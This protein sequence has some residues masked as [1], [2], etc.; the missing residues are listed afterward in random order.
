MST[1]GPITYSY[2]TTDKFA[3]MPI[4]A[5]KSSFPSSYQATYG[6]GQSMPVVKIVYD[7][8]NGTYKGTGLFSAPQTIVMDV[9]NGTGTITFNT[10]SSTSSSQFVMTGAHT[11]SYSTSVLTFTGTNVAGVITLSDGLVLTKV[12]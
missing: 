5:T 3:F 6:I 1:S 8:L 7:D 10:G 12:S 4:I 9:N 2:S 11:F